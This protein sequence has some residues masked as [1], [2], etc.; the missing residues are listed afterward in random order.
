[1][2][3]EQHCRRVPRREKYVGVLRCEPEGRVPVPVDAIRFKRMSLYHEPSSAY[4][5]PSLV[6]NLLVSPHVEG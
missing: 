1:M 5:R 2:R 6:A 4:A 3:D